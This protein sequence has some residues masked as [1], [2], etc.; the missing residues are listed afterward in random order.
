VSYLSAAILAASLRRDDR[1]Y[2]PMF[3]APC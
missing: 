2:I 1:S 3:M